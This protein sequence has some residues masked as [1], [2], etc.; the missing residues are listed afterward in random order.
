MREP[1]CAWGSPST[2]SP[3]RGGLEDEGASSC[4]EA[5][6]L[7][8][9]SQPNDLS[10]SF[11]GNH[12]GLI[13]TSTPQGCFMYRKSLEPSELLEYNSRLVAESTLRLIHPREPKD[14]DYSAQHRCATA[15]TSTTRL[16]PQSGL[17]RQ[18][19]SANG[20]FNNSSRLN[21]RLHRQIAH[22]SRLV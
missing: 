9:H 4:R 1:L 3:G 10:E 8:I 11:S 19:G 22:G 15:T 7:V 20:N 5:P 13:I 6:V 14:F 21:S 17:L 16:A 12:L 2:T 18:I